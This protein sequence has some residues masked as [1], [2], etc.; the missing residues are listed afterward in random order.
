MPQPVLV[1]ELGLYG[2]KPQDLVARA[3]GLRHSLEERR[4]AFGAAVDQV[5]AHLAAERF[6]DAQVAIDALPSIRKD[7]P[8]T[9][10]LRDLFDRLRVVP[11]DVPPLRSRREDLEPLAH[12]LLARIGARQGRALRFSPPFLNV[13]LLLHRTRVALF[14]SFLSLL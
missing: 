10:A 2:F 12:V 4:K 1:A 11:I 5:H 8:E 14:T 13:P 3:K 6:V 9:L 7:Q